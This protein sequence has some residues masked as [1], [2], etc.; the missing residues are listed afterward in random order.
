MTPP[1]SPEA[2]IQRLRDRIEGLVDRGRHICA[3][4]IPTD[5]PACRTCGYTSDVHLLR[6]L[7]SLVASSQEALHW[8]VQETSRAQTERDAAQEALRAAERAR[9]EAQ[10][11]LGESARRI[12]CAGPVAHRIDVLRQE[13]TAALQAKEQELRE[14][15]RA[16][17]AHA[18]QCADAE[19]FANKL[20]LAL[21]A[22]EQKIARLREALLSARTYV[23][24]QCGTKG[25]TAGMGEQNLARI[26]AALASSGAKTP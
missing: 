5:M 25:F 10:Q 7:L 4:F 26:D 2:L 17:D 1:P 19:R 16:R 18:E 12:N 3:E 6:D 24:A 8:H 9:D 22:K 15:E 23:E 20:D 11:A 14:A 21:Q 13:H